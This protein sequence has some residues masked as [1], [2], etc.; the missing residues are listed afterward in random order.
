MENEFECF[1]ALGIAV[2]ALLLMVRYVLKG[3]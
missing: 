2:V 1:F 3:K